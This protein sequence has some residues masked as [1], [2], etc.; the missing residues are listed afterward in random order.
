MGDQ[1]KIIRKWYDELEGE[2]EYDMI[3]EISEVTGNKVVDDED[4]NKLLI[5]LK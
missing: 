1:E 5:L 2:S 4:I 3:Q